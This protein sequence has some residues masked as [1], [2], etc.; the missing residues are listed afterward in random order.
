M[1]T[2][3]RRVLG[4]VAVASWLLLD[5]IRTA[6]PLIASL[7][8]TSLLVALA[9]ALAA[10]A[11]GGVLAWLCALAGRAFGPGVVMLFM[12]GAVGVL[13]LGLPLLDGAWLINA[14][15]YLLALALTT[16]VL[17]ARMALGNGGPS[18]LVAGTALGGAA[19][20]AE[21]TVLR[22][23][24]AV[25]RGDLWG[26][27]A[28]AVVAAL[29][30]FNGWRCI[31]LEP[32]RSSRGW[33]SYG[34]F[35]SL[36]VSVFANVAWVNALVDVR[37]STGAVLTMLSLL[38][39]ALLAAQSHRTSPIVLSVLAA[40]GLAA[41]A[42]VLLRE[43][44]L[45]GYALPVAV[46]TTALA[47]TKVM[48]PALSS[49][50]RRLGAA[51]VFGLA[52]VV[53]L[54]LTQMDYDLATPGPSTLALV[55]AGAAILSAS[56][57]RAWWRE[58]QLAAI[59]DQS[60]PVED[61]DTNAWFAPTVPSGW[62]ASGVLLRAGVGLVIA[63]G[64]GWWTH[65]SFESE[66]A[67]SKDFLIAPTAMTWNVNGGVMPRLTGG[68]EVPLEAMVSTM[69]SAGAD[70]IMLQEVNRGRL[71][72][73]GTDMVEFLAGELRLPYVYAGAH[74]PQVGN[75][76]LT[77]RAHGNPRTL[78]LPDGSDGQARS[79]VAVDFMG[80]TY[81]TAHVDP[82][83]DAE[84]TGEEQVEA[85]VAW[86]D[87]PQPLVIGLSAASEP[88]VAT[89]G[90]IADAGLIGAQAALDVTG[91]TFL[92]TDA[93]GGEVA[94]L[95]FL[96]GRG[97]EFTSVEILGVGYSDHL[98]VLAR[99]VTGATAPVD[100]GDDVNEAQPDAGATASPSPT[101]TPT[102]SASAG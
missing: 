51:T 18:A 43:G 73:G 46:A 66:R 82:S 13:R 38:T 28:L 32:V 7:L 86:L 71:L 21:Q 53:P 33:W 22:T 89:L 3:Q 54:L 83:G 8:D 31:H 40:A 96:L 99:A 81:A 94:T 47:T 34:L 57:W 92:G 77:S 76:I 12:V 39:A 16:V 88:E 36:L 79:A 6:G 10:F 17:A 78:S 65:A 5:S 37:M 64:L 29:A 68:P 87:V 25:W 50:M 44:D 101:P 49:P 72:A 80:A 19:A 62:I 15:L 102:A 63:G 85:L 35:W 61:A 14:G 84:R 1:D 95:D 67:L 75:A 42:V 90:S 55:I 70:V 24:D 20:V 56:L 11:V 60:E 9:T 93:G 48:R 52:I 58:A 41:L 69:S 100:P 98:P 97:V 45:A 74:E 23:W 59:A 4:L 30:I 26:W 91:P 27:A 2:A